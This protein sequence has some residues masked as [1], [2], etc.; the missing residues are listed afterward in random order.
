[1]NIIKNRY[2]WGIN[3]KS[4]YPSMPEDENLSQDPHQ[5]TAKWMVISAWI[6]GMGML[7]LFFDKLL[8]K[9]TNP[10]QNPISSQG[11]GGIEVSLKRNKYGHY[12]SA[13]LI[14]GKPVVFLLDTGATDVSIPMHM[15]QQLGLDIGARH[16]VQTANGS[17]QVASTQ[18]D[19]LAIGAITLN[20]VAANLNP[21][22]TDDEILLGMSALKH[23]DFSQNG[24]W[25]VLR[26]R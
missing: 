12:V 6:V 11:Q 17:V 9:Q 20:N 1:M 5:K 26:S 15:A 7:V 14:N 2:Y 22:V 19:Q 13:G 16:Y 10:N 3:V 18:I 8:D 24:D 21:G 25:L 23:L 4:R